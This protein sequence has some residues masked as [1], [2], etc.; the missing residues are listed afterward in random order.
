MI[1][2]RV[3][4][5]LFTD[6]QELCLQFNQLLCQPEFAALTAPNIDISCSDAVKDQAT[7]LHITL[8]QEHHSLLRIRK[9]FGNGVSGS[10]TAIGTIADIEGDLTELLDL[11][12]PSADQHP[13][14]VAVRELLGF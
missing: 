8:T 4:I 14:E 13:E 2:T 11:I 10:T 6:R 5:I 7:E 9:V 3:S 1:I 12:T